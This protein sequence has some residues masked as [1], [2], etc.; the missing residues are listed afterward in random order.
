MPGG[1]ISDQTKT[2]AHP[3]GRK[4]REAVNSY[5]VVCAWIGSSEA[6]AKD[7]YLQVTDAHFE[8]ATS[9]AQNPAQSGG[10]T[11]RYGAESGF[12]RCAKSLDFIER[13]CTVRCGA[14]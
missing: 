8:R 6:V 12:G 14:K 7:H 5:H 10:G 11:G 2:R 3:A 9:A 4:F 1:R 13:F